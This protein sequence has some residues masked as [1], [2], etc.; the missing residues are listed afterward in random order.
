MIISRKIFHSV[1]ILC[2]VIFSSFVFVGC[3]DKGKKD[4]VVQKPLKMAV[5]DVEKVI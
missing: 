2:F 3:T 5:V 4:E 1:F